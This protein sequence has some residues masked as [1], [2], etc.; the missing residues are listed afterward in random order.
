[1]TVREALVAILGCV[2]YTPP[3]EN[4]R[5]TEL[6]GNVLSR[7]LLSRAR[8]ALEEDANLTEHSQH[9]PEES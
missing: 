4:C 3:H 7:S 9:T 8:V 5:P 2:D 6:V 1:M